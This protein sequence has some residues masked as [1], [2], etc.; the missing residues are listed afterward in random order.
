VKSTATTG[1]FP[2]TQAL[3]LGGIYSGSSQREKYISRG[4]Y[5]GYGKNNESREEEGCGSNFFRHPMVIGMH[6]VC[7]F[8]NYI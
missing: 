5:R 8:N 4:N 3:C 1:S 2:T 6:R 7:V